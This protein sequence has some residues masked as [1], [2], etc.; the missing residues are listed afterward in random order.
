MAD[1]DGVR[2]GPQA[3]RW[4]G[5]CPTGPRKDLNLLLG[6]PGHV[7]SRF[8]HRGGRKARDWSEL[9]WAIDG[10][11]R[12]SCGGELCQGRLEELKRG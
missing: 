8:P 2:R 11:R 5:A 9:L 3:P 10:P 7:S 12:S 4:P 6:V 1:E